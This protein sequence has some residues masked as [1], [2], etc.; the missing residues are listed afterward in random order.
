[1]PSDLKI[2]RKKN[3]NGQKST[4]Q[5][6]IDRHTLLL[7]VTEY[8]IY[9]LQCQFRE[10]FPPEVSWFSPEVAKKKFVKLHAV[11]L[12]VYVCLFVRISVDTTVIIIKNMSLPIQ[13]T[14]NLW[15]SKSSK[16]WKPQLAIR[17]FV[18][19]RTK[20]IYYLTMNTKSKQLVLLWFQH[21]FNIPTH[22]I[23]LLKLPICT[24]VTYLQIPFTGY[25]A[26]KSYCSKK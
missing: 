19:K 6:L 4:K 7:S 21:N 24:L 10:L 26:C 2:W 3:T 8:I 23:L 14:T 11:T 15:I 20:K 22:A 25:N 12:C 16:K 9:A 18:K 1:M 13:T 17:V 5:N